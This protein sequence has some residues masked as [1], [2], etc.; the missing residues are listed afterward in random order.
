MPL[1][2]GMLAI[3][4]YSSGVQRNAIVLL[5]LRALFSHGILFAP[6]LGER[7]GD[8]R[9]WREK[10]G[11]AVCDADCPMTHALGDVEDEEAPVDERA[12]VCFN[13][14]FMF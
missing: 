10:A 14:C 12:H 7:V 1:Q 13:V 4:S 9:A 6:Q 2:A 3:S 8:L 11:I 5:R